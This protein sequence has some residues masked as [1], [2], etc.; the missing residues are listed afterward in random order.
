MLALGGQTS[1]SGLVLDGQWFALFIYGEPSLESLKGFFTNPDVYRLIS[2]KPISKEVS[3]YM[4]NNGQVFA[5]ALVR[6]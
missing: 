2:S 5:R 3:M 1:S 4:Y 6:I